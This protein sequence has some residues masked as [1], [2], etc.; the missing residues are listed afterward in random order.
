M[1]KPLLALL[2]VAAVAVVAVVAMAVV[3]N[4]P[5]L[6]TDRRIDKL[7]RTY[8]DPE[9]LFKRLVDDRDLVGLI[10]FSALN[11]RCSPAVCDDRRRLAAGWFGSMFR[12]AI[13]VCDCGTYPLR[14]LP[15]L[16]SPGYSWDLGHEESC[17]FRHA[18]RNVQQSWGSYIKRK[19]EEIREKTA[20]QRR[21]LHQ[22]A[23]ALRQE[24]M[25]SLVRS[26][27]VPESS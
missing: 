2:A 22:E 4:R 10:V 27:S 20:A 17:K 12:F 3:E 23:A 6:R 15:D 11:C 26:L 18:W 19:K 16:H 1:K 5:E 14:D 25:D 7:L 24:R 8:D 21:K 9:Q 13:E